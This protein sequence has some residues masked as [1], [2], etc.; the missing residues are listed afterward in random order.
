[1]L[2]S[3][4]LLCSEMQNFNALQPLNYGPD[5]ECF[6]LIFCCPKSQLI[7]CNLQLQDMINFPKWPA[8]YPLLAQ[9]VSKRLMI[10][11]QPAAMGLVWVIFQILF[12]NCVRKYPIFCQFIIH[13]YLKCFEII[14]LFS[15]FPF[16]KLKTY[17]FLQILLEMPP[18]I[19]HPHGP[20]QLVRF[21]TPF[22]WFLFH[23]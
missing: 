6:F 3:T 11:N 13:M 21:I 1:M 14:P 16:F 22:P 8:R 18:L 4:M 9:R 2:W 23:G 20:V 7:M 5:F 19:N 17:P 12:S 15:I 10:Q